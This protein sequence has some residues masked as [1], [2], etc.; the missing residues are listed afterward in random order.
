MSSIRAFVAAP[1]DDVLNQHFDEFIE[2]VTSLWPESRWV[3]AE[4]RHLTLRFLGQIDPEPLKD[5]SNTLTETVKLLPELKVTATHIGPFPPNARSHLVAA[6]LNLPAHLQ[7]LVDGLDGLATAVGVQPR[8][9]AFR[10]HITLGRL[11]HRPDTG[12]AV[13]T[14]PFEGTLRVTRLAV[15]R[16]DTVIDGR[17]YTPLSEYPLLAD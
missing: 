15:F 3:P 17:A 1:V 2:G 7:R 8:K 9:K 14:S 13:I 6:H 5:F 16:S 4:H 11:Q 10:P 12:E